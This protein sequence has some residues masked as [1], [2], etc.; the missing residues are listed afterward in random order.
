MKALLKKDL[1]TVRRYLRVAALTPLIFALA[2]AVAEKGAYFLVLAPVMSI[3]NIIS[4]IAYDERFHW[5]RT[6]DMLPVSRKAQ[7]TEKYLLLLFYLGITMLLCGA[8][9]LIHFGWAETEWMIMLMLA[10]SL[11]PPSFLLPLVFRLGVEKARLLYYIAVG[12]CVALGMQF[13]SEPGWLISAALGL[14]AV[15]ALLLVFALSWFLSVRF[16]E[17]REF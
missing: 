10:L 15:L 3:G 5:D 17:Q 8:A 14:A 13:R 2:G 1:L 11:L 16:Y 6:C 7:V 9:A 4:L 12:L